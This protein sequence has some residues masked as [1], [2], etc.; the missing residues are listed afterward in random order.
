[1]ISK[2]EL[3]EIVAALRLNPHVVEKDYA[4][5]WALAG[6][7]AHEELA[8]SWVF[9]GGTCL[10]KC[11]FETN[12]FS[13]DLDFTLQD[14]GHLD[15]AFLKRVFSE[16][17][18][19]VYEQ[20][21]LEFP[22]DSQD[23]EIFENPRGN[24]SCQGKLS[25]RGPVSPRSGGLPRIKL[26]LTAD[27]RLVLAPVRMQIFHPYSDAPDG[28][29]EVL[30]Y[31]YE[32]AFGEKVRA[33][34]ERTRPR[35][36]YD[37]INL[38]R[39]AEARPSPAVLLDVLRQKCEFKGIAVPQM[40]VLDGHRADLEGS[41]VSMLAHQLQDLPPVASF[42]EAL[43]E[44][45]AWLAGE[46]APASP[47]PYTIAPGETVIRERTLRL[48]V[49]GLAQSHLEVVRFAAA[50]RLCVELDYTDELGRRSVRVIEPYSLRHTQENNIILHAWSVDRDQH[51]SYRVDRIKGARTTGRTFAPRFAVELTPSGPVSIPPTQRTSSGSSGGA[52]F[53]SVRAQR[54]PVRRRARRS[55]SS[56]GRGPTYIYQCGMCGKKFRRKTRSSRMNRHKAPGGF[57]CSGRTGFLV[58]IKY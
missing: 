41:W 50:N 44:F 38:Y 55:A 23:F 9:K 32:E 20:S 58:D 37:V 12:R 48:P 14:A 29:I 49:S 30:A 24:P 46:H 57:P 25:Y 33:L 10:K 31:A 15:E 8:D 26:D 42:W 18:E 22:A 11:Y 5:G 56:F 7:F 6:I 19:W 54:R 16:I 35:D 45:F 13:E 27:E 51:R 1:M 4:L 28:G 43:P 3:L 52:G 34:A 36:L 47:A 17:S 40:G 53:G 39:N 2:R 21:G